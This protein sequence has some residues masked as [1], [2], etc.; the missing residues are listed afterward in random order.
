MRAAI[1]C[2][3][4]LSVAGCAA[5]ALMTPE[6]YLGLA[7]EDEYPEGRGALAA[8]V[9]EAGYY[10]VSEVETVPYEDYAA[11]AAE[12]RVK[13]EVAADPYIYYSVEADLDLAPTPKV[14]EWVKILERK[15]TRRP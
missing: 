1:L 15:K 8:H 5:P 6:G 13:Y 7:D 2:A 3:V 10:A 14:R 12:G 9:A 4:A 11:A